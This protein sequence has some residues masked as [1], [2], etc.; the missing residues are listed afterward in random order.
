VNVKTIGAGICG[1]VLFAM[2]NP[3]TAVAQNVQ[4]AKRGGTVTIPL[5]A[6]ERVINPALRA[7]GGVVLVGGKIM[8]PLIDKSFEG[9]RPVLAT[10][11]TSS[12]DGLHIT[13]KLRHGVKW[14]DGESFSCDDVAFSAMELWKRRLNFSTTLQANLESVDCKDPL[15]AVFNYA[16][17]MPLSLFVAAMPDLGYPVP[18]HL[19]KDTDID[20]NKYNN[21]PVGTGPFKFLEYQRGQYII[22]QRNENYWNK[23]FPYLDRIVFRILNDKSAIAAALE[24][25]EVQESL[26]NGLS[27]ADVNR[28]SRDSQFVVSTKGYE[29]VSQ[30]STIQFNFR[31]PILAKLKV[32][33]AIYRAINIPQAIETIFHGRA[34]PGMGPIPSTDKANFTNIVTKYAYD[35]DLAR[36]ELDEAGY[37][38]GKDG[39]RFKLRHRSAPWGETASYWGQFFAQSMKKVGIEVELIGNDPPAFVKAV[40]GDS[41][42][43]TANDWHNYRADPAISTTSWLRSGAP[44]G[45][46]WTN[47]MGWK[48]DRVDSLIDKAAGE[49]DSKA[50]AGDYQ[51]LQRL[52]MKDLPIIYAI[53]QQ[54]VSVTSKKL[55][56]HHNNPRWIYSSW[57]DLAV[58]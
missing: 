4:N 14:H 36:K 56:N 51:E 19:Y 20:K 21:A 7:S 1:L 6:E 38:V 16:K 49:L 3:A 39:I 37:P 45:V 9:F 43:D 24:A 42:F 12:R 41:D 18:K 28:F 15:T 29:A 25:G 52:V 31:N 23:G 46:P 32:R 33:Q 5:V 8:E 17:P 50:R 58:E 53:E 26:N 48:D 11:W 47:Q 57:Y 27:I 35:P 30:H 40:Y 2:I 10:E 22:L 34:V 54:S 55:R 44:A 13:V